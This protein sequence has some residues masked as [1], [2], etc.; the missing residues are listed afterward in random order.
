MGKSNLMR[1]WIKICGTTNLEDA[2]ACVE[3]GVDALGFI[4]TESARLVDPQTAKQIVSA[5]PEHIEKIGVF[6]NEPHDVVVNTVHEAGLTGVQLHG[7]EP[8]AY[9]KHLVRLFGDTP[10]KIMKAIPAELGRTS[11]LGYF[12]GGE[13]LVDAVMIDSGT[14]QL[15]GGTG[16][17]FDWLRSGDFILW[18]EQRAKVIVAG[19]LSPENVSA[20]VSLFHPFGVDVVSGVEASKGKKDHTKVRAFVE[21]VRRADGAGP[22]H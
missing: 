2:Q 16:Q 8:P 1:T 15:R 12:D 7:D 21:S 13:E 20:A 6:V 11:G 18:L 9:V 14:V 22:R 19:G 10:V 17:V 5:I 3:A 4:F